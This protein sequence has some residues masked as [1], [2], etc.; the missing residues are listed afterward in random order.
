MLTKTKRQQI[1]IAVRSERGLLTDVALFS[2]RRAAE[3]RECRWRKAANRDYDES[4]VF[5]RSIR[6]PKAVRGAGF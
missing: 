2:S 3:V 4:A 1:W 6:L 5:C